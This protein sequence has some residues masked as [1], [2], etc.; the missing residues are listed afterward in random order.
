[1]VPW[2]I[3]QLNVPPLR[4]V[5]AHRPYVEPRRPYTG[6]ATTAKDKKLPKRVPGPS[7]FDCRHFLRRQDL[8]PIRIGIAKN[9]GQ[10]IWT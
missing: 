3:H 1:M 2:M 6:P 9:E 8:E 4:T 10:L 7:T 5:L